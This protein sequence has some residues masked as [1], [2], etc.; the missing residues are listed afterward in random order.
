M[1]RLVRV[2]I[3]ENFAT[4]GIIIAIS[5]M[6]VWGMHLVYILIN[7]PID[8]KD[9]WFWCHLIM[10]SWLFTG[11]FITAHDSMHGTISRHKR[12]NNFLGFFATLLFAG[13]WYPMLLKKHKLHHIH[14]GT[15]LDP[16]Y[17]VGNQ[18]FFAWW[19][20]FMKQ[21]VTLW[22]ILIMAVLFNIGLIFFTETQLIV[23]WIIPSILATFQLFYFGTYLPHH[24]PHT[25]EMEPH[26]AR[27]QKRNH[28]WAMLS[29]YFFGYHYEH[30]A[31]PQT[32]WWKLYQI[33]AKRLD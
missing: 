16:D 26:K 13:M 29:C 18:N 19:F 8:L 30:H 15:V 7:Q 25:P 32:P 4:M 17:K 10:Q 14:S 22:Q 5:I 27:S 31:S 6:L 3:H 28:L 1:S 24:L 33:K 2:K 20:S 21:Y 23:L 11:L 12:V 9:V